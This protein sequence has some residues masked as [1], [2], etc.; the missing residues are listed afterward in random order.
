MSR[1]SSVGRE[2][3][4]IGRS[5]ANIAQAL[6][7][8]TPLIAASTSQ[9]GN[10]RTRVRKL[11]LSRGRRAALTLQGQYMGICVA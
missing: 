5:L 8:L 1:R 9:S 3:Q 10:P 4:A 7:R 2:I 11:T 6:T